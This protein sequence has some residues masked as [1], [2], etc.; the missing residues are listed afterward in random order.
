MRLRAL[1]SNDDPRFPRIDFREGLNVVFARVHDPFVQDKDSHNLGKSFLIRVLDFVLLGSCTGTHV[2]RKRKDL[3]GDFVF[4]L[5]IS[6]RSGAHVTIRRPVTG[7]AAICIHVSNKPSGDLT[8]LA[9]EDWR[10][11]KLG[12]QKAR[13]I[14]NRIINLTQISP[15]TF[16]KGLGYLMRDQGDYTDEFLISRFR[17]GKD[18]DWKPFVGLLL[19]FDHDLLMEKYDNDRQLAAKKAELIEAQRAGQGGAKEVDELRG[20][21][22]VRTNQIKRLRSR[23]SSFDF[24]DIES[25]IT[26]ETV[27][28]IES[29]IADANEERFLLEREAHEIDRALDTQFGFEL[30]RIQDAF[31]EA[32]RALPDLLV[33]S[34]EELVSFNE[35]MS[36]DRR[37]RLTA[38]RSQL[39]SLMEELDAQRASLNND[40]VRS[41]D[42]ITQR[43][44]LKKFEGLQRELIRMEEELLGLRQQL[45][46]LGE[47]GRV[48]AELRSL[49]REQLRLITRI[50]DMIDASTD[51]YEVIRGLFDSFASAILAVSAILVTRVNS[52]GNLDFGTRIIEKGD[53]S[54]ETAEAEG[55]SYK[56]AL[57]VC[58][59]LALLVAY[60]RG[61]FY[62]FVY[63][64]GVFEGFD[65]RRKVSLLKTVRRLCSEYGFQ[66]ILTVIDADLP[67][68]DDDDKVLFTD[69]EVV[70]E[71]HDQGTSGRLFRM[72]PF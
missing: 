2:F 26:R 5:E 49:E 17:R 40:R 12:V 44:T 10:H 18:I 4:Y 24:V 27:R 34:Y 19:G 43:Q 53:T 55:T 25:E 45:K 1:Y 54:R 60:A 62:R 65:N 50:T 47:A 3:F 67:R 8:A 58:N 32:R 29:R 21:I 14:L 33:R 57:C 71:L 52:A 36:A 59:D 42:I 64:D 70:R 15:Y 41:L 9:P 72:E 28:T 56:K 68:D 31:A 30:K 22:G 51:Q 69:D 7:H 63:H 38:R 20:V 16:R 61:G 6:V 35:R 37:D 66:Y 46:D 23:V 48:A 11:H 13:A 39:A